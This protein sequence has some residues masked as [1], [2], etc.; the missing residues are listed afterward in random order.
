MAKKYRKPPKRLGPSFNPKTEHKLQK[1]YR[2]DQWIYV[3]YDV[4][5]K[6]DGRCMLCG[7]GA[8]DGRTLHVDHIKPVRYYWDLRLETDNL[9][10]LCDLCNKGKG[11]R[12][13]DDWRPTIKDQI[14]RPTA[15]GLVIISPR[16]NQK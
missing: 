10:V 15:D 8:K 16:Q 9:Q 3:R 4:L 12:H 6:Y 11:A 2:S 14:R 7:H 1:F 5:S 13:E